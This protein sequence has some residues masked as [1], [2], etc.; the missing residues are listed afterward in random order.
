VG[1]HRAEHDDVL[2]QID[3]TKAADVA[4]VRHLL[5]ALLAHMAQE[6]KTLLTEKLLRDD[7]IQLD[8]G[9]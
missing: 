1:E 6:E 8:A 5:A 3:P 7:V 9:D 4:H 2:A